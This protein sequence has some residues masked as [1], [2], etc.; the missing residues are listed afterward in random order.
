MVTR[1]AENTRT[2]RSIGEKFRPRLPAL[3]RWRD[4]PHR[5]SISLFLDERLS[6]YGSIIS[7]ALIIG[8]VAMSPFHYNYFKIVIR[9]T[10]KSWREQLCTPHFRLDNFSHWTYR[11]RLALAAIY[12]LLLVIYATYHHAS[13][14]GAMGSRDLTFI[15]QAQDFIHYI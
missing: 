9:L 12:I 13:L 4:E 10:L 11:P 14:S 15:S 8:S 3:R 5:A 6:R 1:H 7:P 2:Y